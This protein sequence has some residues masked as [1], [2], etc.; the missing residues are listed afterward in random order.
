MKWSILLILVVAFWSWAIADDYVQ[1]VWCHDGSKLLLTAD[2]Y[3]GLYCWDK[4]RD[5]LRQIT[6]ARG[7]GYRASW[8]PDNNRIAFKMLR[9]EAGQIQQA[10]VIYDL[11]AGKFIYLASFSV[12]CGVPSFAND[13]RIAFSIDN[14]IYLLTADYTLLRKIKIDH[15]ANLCV[16]SP[17]GRWIA[18]ND[19]EEQICL[20][21]VDTGLCRRITFTADA[22]HSP[23][24]APDS[25]KLLVSTVSGHLH[26]IVPDNS[27]VM[28]VATGENPVWDNDSETVLFCQTK[29]REG[30]VASRDVYT[31]HYSGGEPCLLTK[32]CLIAGCAIQPQS[33]KIL[34]CSAAGKGI[35]FANYRRGRAPIFPSDLEPLVLPM[36]KQAQSTSMHIAPLAVAVR[37]TRATQVIQGVPYLHQVY[38]TPNWYNGHWACGATS[39]MMAIAYYGI[40]PHWDCTVSV[41]YSHV[42]H[43]GRY[44][45]EKY[46]YSGYTFDK[47]ATDPS[48]NA[49]YGGYGFICQNNWEN[50]K[51]HMATYFQKHG[52]NSSVDW[53]PTWNE[54]RAHIDA[55]HPMVI[56][57]SLTSAGHYILG[58]GYFTSQHTVVVNDPYG[59]KNTPGYP[60]YDGAGAKYDWP[61]YNNGYK[62]LNTVHCLIYA[63]H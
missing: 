45:C 11:A 1:P 7:A 15:Y 33:G 14:T 47:M 8:A 44:I 24:W 2:G 6:E 60:S 35:F 34:L 53:S 56:L 52:I 51:A 37:Q 43:Y 23:I 4:S 5:S 3:E 26:V 20:A 59:N 58:I 48:G 50:T 21:A 49:A 29:T 25:S 63:Q 10:P 18:F 19:S 9:T 31:V 40:L 62:N 61:G 30:E 16:I 28:S 55:N 12:R 39:A 54:L 46:T 41:P 17:D 42:S 57:T 22:Y 32:G 27:S 13:G 38:D 36:D